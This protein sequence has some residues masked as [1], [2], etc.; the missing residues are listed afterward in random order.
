M[1]YK[2]DIF[3]I[4]QVTGGK[5]DAFSHIVERHKDHV[6]NLAFRICG[7]REEAEEIAQDTFMKAYRALSGFKKQSSFST[8]LYSIAYNTSISMVRT[9]RKDILSLDEFPADAVDFM[10]SGTSEEEAEEEYRRSLVN[11]ALQK[12]AAEERALITL[13]YFDD[14]STEEI[15]GITGITRSNVKIKLFRARQKMASIIEKCEKTTL[16]YNEH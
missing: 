9:R 12:I 3:Y 16:I 2:G 11:F 13:Y 10:G 8:W 7:N 14:M 4:D 6:F 15:A 1:D 5:R